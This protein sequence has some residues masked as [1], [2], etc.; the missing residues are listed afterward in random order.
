MSSSLET[1]LHLAATL[2]FEELAYLCPTELADDLQPDVSAAHVVSVRFRGRIRGRL[3]LAVASE[4][5][6]GIAMN[7]LGTDEPPPAP[8]Q[9]DAL[10]E[11]ANVIC[12]NV[13]PA[14]A[15]TTTVLDLAAPEVVEP[16]DGRESS[17]PPTAQTRFGLEGGWASVKLFVNHKPQR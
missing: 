15:G 6:P 12:G 14:V 3:E 11:I 1:K 17:Q 2:T 4:L 8:V 13:L 9:R 16:A 10:G 5:L 7:M